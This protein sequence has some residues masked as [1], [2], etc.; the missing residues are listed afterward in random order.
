MRTK[1]CLMCKKRKPHDQFGTIDSRG[2]TLLSRCKE[3][4]STASKRW[5]AENKAKCLSCQKCGHKQAIYLLMD[6]LCQDCYRKNNTPLITKPTPV[7]I[8]EKHINKVRTKPEYSEI[9]L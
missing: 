5:Y 6:N 3:C 7:M 8:L 9:C 4:C 2:G 1:P